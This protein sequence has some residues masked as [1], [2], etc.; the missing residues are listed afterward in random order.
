M[1]KVFKDQIRR[2]LE[3]YIDGMLIKSRSLDNHLA[4]LK[5]NFIIMKNNKVRINLAKYVFE[6]TVGKFLGFMLTKRGIKV[7][8]TKCKAI[9]EMRSLTIVKYV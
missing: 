8:L 9:L 5:D 3:V 6:V 2:N 7:N 4:D 1:N